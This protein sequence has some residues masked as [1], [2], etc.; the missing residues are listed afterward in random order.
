MPDRKRRIAA[1][2]LL[3]ALGGLI[4]GAPAS[5]AALPIACVSPCDIS[6]SGQTGY[7]APAT[8]IASGTTVV[9]HTTEDHTHPTTE[10]VAT[11]SGACFNAN[12][13][14][15]RP[16]EPVVFNLTGAGVTATQASS[17]T[18]PCPSA[19]AVGD[20]SYALFYHCRLHPN[21]IG[22]LRVE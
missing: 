10:G 20:G 6:A 7:L 9:W 22:M 14:F 1:R 21:M 11:G 16:S 18:L 3:L 17:G 8:D 15:E 2:G 12:I 13:T 19:V 4:A 5:P